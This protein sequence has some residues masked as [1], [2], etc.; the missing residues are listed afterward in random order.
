VPSGA[1]GETG[2]SVSFRLR[3][4]RT[5][6]RVSTAWGGRQHR[7]HSAGAPFSRSRESPSPCKGALD[8]WPLCL[9]TLV[10]PNRESGRYCLSYTAV[11]PIFLPVASVPFVRTVRLLPSA[12]TTT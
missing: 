1:V 7:Q 4:R 10:P 8:C 3:I 12:D 9:T 5:R 11:L 2:E 6:C